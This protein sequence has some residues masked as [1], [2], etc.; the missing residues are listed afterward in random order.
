MYCP[1]CNAILPNDSKFCTNC[2]AQINPDASL[3]QASPDSALNQNQAHNG[4]QQN[5]GS[6][7]PSGQ[8]PYNNGGYT[9]DGNAP[10]G[11]A[12]YGNAPYGG[13][14]YSAPYNQNQYQN[15]NFNMPPQ[16]NNM[17][18]DK[19][20]VGFGILSFFIPLLGL[21]L[22]LVWKDKFPQK[23]KGCG[24]AAIVGAVLH[25]VAGFING[26]FSG[27]SGYNTV[28]DFGDYVNLAVNSLIAGL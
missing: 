8:T 6:P 12:P 16:Y 7:Y 1:K 14:Q 17:P 15:P 23:A 21:I 26:V 28:Y 22:Y 3:G 25:F 4:Y 18:E 11:N 10:Y 2:G 24:I 5:A 9:P 19:R 27:M 20:S 13:N